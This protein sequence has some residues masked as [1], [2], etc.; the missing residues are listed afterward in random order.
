M[1]TLIEKAKV[2]FDKHPLLTRT[3]ITAG[4]TFLIAFS[5]VLVLFVVLWVTGIY[6]TLET[7]LDLKYDSPI[8]LIPL[9]SCTALFVLCLMAG[10]LMY[11][12]KYKR[13]KA[14]TAFYNAIAPA[15]CEESDK[16]AK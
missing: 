5:V 11:F 1:N 15:F 6:D 4:K 13:A 3:L 12:H 14:K 7:A 2:F 16:K 10:F 8:L 9:W